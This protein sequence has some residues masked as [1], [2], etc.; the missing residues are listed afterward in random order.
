MFRYPETSVEGATLMNETRRGGGQFTRGTHRPVAPTSPHVSQIQIQRRSRARRRVEP[1]L[2]VPSP[3][4]I[5]EARAAI[6]T[7][8]ASDE[9]NRYV[10]PRGCVPRRRAPIQRW[11]GASAEVEPKQLVPPPPLILKEA[12][13]RLRARGKL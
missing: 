8:F 10:K 4:L 12:P 1:K 6:A 5:L 7:S 3:T 11:S 9:A 2:P 13:H